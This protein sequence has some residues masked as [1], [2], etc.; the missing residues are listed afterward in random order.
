MIG[1]HINF[2]ITEPKPGQ[3]VHASNNTCVFEDGHMLKSVKSITI[4]HIA[5]ERIYATLDVFVKKVTSGPLSAVE[6]HGKDI[7]PQPAQNHTKRTNVPHIVLESDV[8]GVEPIIAEQAKWFSIG[9]HGEQTRKGNKI[10]YFNHPMRVMECLESYGIDDPE[11]LAAAVLHD[12]CEDTPITLKTISARFGSRVASI[13]AELTKDYPDGARGVTRRAYVDRFLNASPEACIIKIVDRAD[14]LRDDFS[15]DPK[16]RSTYAEEGQAFLAM[17]NNNEALV[18]R[19]EDD[20]T[21][22]AAY[23]LAVDDLNE[24]CKPPQV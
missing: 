15:W 8:V 20:V 11:I 6:H 1:M 7:N 18:K 23:N 14:N 3:I 21:F 16:Y 13:V 10:P 17:M 5:G 19:N 4:K 22:W 9:A 2:G 12:V 24:A